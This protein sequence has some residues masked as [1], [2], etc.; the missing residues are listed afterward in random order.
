LVAG[1][2]AVGAVVVGAVVVGA[3]ALGAV[4]AAAGVTGRAG[5]FFAT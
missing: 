5:E 2:P 1:L 3:V 4:D